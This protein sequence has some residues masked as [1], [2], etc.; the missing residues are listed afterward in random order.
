[1]GMLY[2]IS[3]DVY[4]KILDQDIEYVNELKQLSDVYF[5]QYKIIISLLKDGNTSRSNIIE[6]VL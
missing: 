6:Y 4:T 1:M 5:S 3:L 2:R